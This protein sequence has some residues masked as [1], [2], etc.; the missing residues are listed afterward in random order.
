MSYSSPHYT[1]TIFN[2]D[3]FFIINR[4]RWWTLKPQWLYTADIKMSG[5][6]QVGQP[7][8]YKDSSAKGQCKFLET[9]DLERKD[10]GGVPASF[11]GGGRRKVSS[12]LNCPIWR[13]ISACWKSLPSSS[14]MYD[15]IGRL[16]STLNISPMTPAPRRTTMEWNNFLNKRGMLY[17]AATPAEPIARTGKSHR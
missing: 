8:R 16:S 13:S 11:F 4:D 3:I 2:D 14:D 6:K 17:A 15:W 10:E 9:N 12:G 5:R 7:H 1:G